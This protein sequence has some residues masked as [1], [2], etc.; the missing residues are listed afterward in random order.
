MEQLS[1]E[2][3]DGVVSQNINVYQRRISIVYTRGTQ[4]WRQVELRGT[5]RGHFAGLVSVHV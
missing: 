4:R 3:R 2:A 1:R 5:G